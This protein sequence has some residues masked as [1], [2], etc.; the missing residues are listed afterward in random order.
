M[1]F[2]LYP[3]ICRLL[4][5][6]FRRWE[7]V[8][9]HLKRFTAVYSDIRPCAYMRSITQSGLNFMDVSARP[10]NK[11]NSYNGHVL[12]CLWQDYTERSVGD[13]QFHLLALLVRIC[14]VLHGQMQDV[15]RKQPIQAGVKD[16]SVNITQNN[17]LSVSRLS[18]ACGFSF[19]TS[20][21]LGPACKQTSHVNYF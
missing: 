15:M 18:K 8:L 6:S 14:R 7:L 21:C 10:C 20:T 9:G 13:K 17:L 19:C 16:Y 12:T 3:L 5:Q 11:G 1:L 4:G 2:L